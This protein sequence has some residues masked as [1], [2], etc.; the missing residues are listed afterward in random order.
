LGVQIPEINVYKFKSK[1]KPFYE[2]SNGRRILVDSDSTNLQDS[3]AEVIDRFRRSNIRTLEPGQV[4][5]QADLQGIANAWLSVS[6]RF[7]DPS[8]D[9]YYGQAR[10][11]IIGPYG[12]NRRTLGDILACRAGVC[13]ELS[14]LSSI[15][16]SEM[17]YITRIASASVRI[18]NEDL[19]GRHAWLEILHPRTHAIIGI[20]DSNFTRQFYS[21]YTIY[22]NLTGAQ[23]LRY[24]IIATP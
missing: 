23:D 15:A 2:A 16:L 18:A 12:L 21:Q 5:S 20:I 11:Q 17:G 22:Y 14:M 6:R 8:D 7:E 1:L 10:N 3:V 9:E 13:R 24:S 4:P 19:E